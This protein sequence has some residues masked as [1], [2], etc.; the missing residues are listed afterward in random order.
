MFADSHVAIITLTAH[1]FNTNIPFSQEIIVPRLMASKVHFQKS[2]PRRKKMNLREMLLKELR[3]SA[4][5]DDALIK[6]HR[7]VLKVNCN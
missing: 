3:E 4:A 2:Q 7:N 1:F 5:K 6:Q